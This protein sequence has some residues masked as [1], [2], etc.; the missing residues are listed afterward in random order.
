MPRKWFSI[1]VLVAVVAMLPATAPASIV[2]FFETFDGVV[3]DKLSGVTATEGTQGFFA[4]GF[5]GNFLRNTAPGSSVPGNP[6]QKTILTLTGLPAHD[7]IDI[8]MQFA[9]IDSWDSTNGIS[10]PDYFNVTVDGVLV[11]QP[12][13][14][15]ASGTVNYPNGL[16]N[17]PDP[18]QLGF[19]SWGDRAYDWGPSFCP[20]LHNIAHTAST[21]TIEFFAS[22]AGWQGRDDESWAI[23]GLMVVVKPVTAPLPGTVL[24]LGSGLAGLLGWRRR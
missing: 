23:D 9:A 1:L 2:V 5:G 7:E 22:G 12:T 3:S 20:E 6:A 4:Y 15:N 21:L 13:F 16:L 17:G 11:F 18:T 14:N 8:N 24:L 19:S 10:A